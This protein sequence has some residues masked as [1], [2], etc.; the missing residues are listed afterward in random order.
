MLYLL[1]W[2]SPDEKRRN[3]YYRIAKS[4]ALNKQHSCVECWLNQAQ[5]K[6]LIKALTA[7]AKEEDKLM[8][9]AI[10]NEKAIVYSKQ[11]A[12][13]FNKSLWVISWSNSLLIRKI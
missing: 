12:L 7:Q 1:A 4:Y 10:P 2:D 6:Q 5:K 3:K 13:L 8:L 11:S 9:L